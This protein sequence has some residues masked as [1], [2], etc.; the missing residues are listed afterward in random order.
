MR[1]QSFHRLALAKQ[2]ELHFLAV[3][4]KALRF[5]HDY[6]MDAVPILCFHKIFMMPISSGVNSIDILRIIVIDT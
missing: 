1:W 4:E 3:F 6:E 5:T 2:L